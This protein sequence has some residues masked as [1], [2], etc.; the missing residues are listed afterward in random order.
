M[1]FEIKKKTRRSVET[2]ASDRRRVCH[3]RRPTQFYTTTMPVYKEG[4]NTFYSIQTQSLICKSDNTP[5]YQVNMA[6][7]YGR[8]KEVFRFG[9]EEF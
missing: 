1:I 3:H 6:I 8:W 9:V 2:A 5:N 7:L 4:A